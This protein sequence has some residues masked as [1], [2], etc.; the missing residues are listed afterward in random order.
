[1]LR[2]S[3]CI[4]RR[5]WLLEIHWCVDVG[6][7]HSSTC[8]TRPH[9][10]VCACCYSHLAFER[11]QDVKTLSMCDRL[12]S[13]I[14]CVSYTL[15]IC[16]IP[17][18]LRAAFLIWCKSFVLSVYRKWCC[19]LA[20]CLAAVSI[21]LVVHMHTFTMC[22]VANESA[23]AGV[24]LGFSESDVAFQHFL[25]PVA[26][27][28]SCTYWSSRVAIDRLRGCSFLWEWC[29]I[30]ARPLTCSSLVFL[31]ILELARCDRSSL[32]L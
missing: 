8:I 1:M 11:S 9:F 4:H 29:C 17:A 20:H 2:C 24:L 10:Y 28:C 21:F 7:L 5:R 12:R 19:I 6:M 15:R 23:N 22:R 16:C 25:S 30:P 27:L 3:I 32:R 31:Y 14:S 26:A 18:V 13:R